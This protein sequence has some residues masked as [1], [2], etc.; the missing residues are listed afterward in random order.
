[1]VQEFEDAAYALSV[2]EYTFQNLAD[3]IDATNEGDTL[4]LSADDLSYKIIDNN[5]YISK[6]Y[7][8]DYLQSKGITGG[9]SSIKAVYA[10]N[11]YFLLRL[12]SLFT[13]LHQNTVI[14][15]LAT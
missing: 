6:V 5:Y 2:N 9:V 10:E 15:I 7:T 1:M 3:K 11:E 8:E 13:L 12:L 4:N 14:H